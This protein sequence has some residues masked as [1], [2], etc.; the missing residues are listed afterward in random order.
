MQ[1]GPYQGLY[2]RRSQRQLHPQLT[3]HRA[4]LIRCKHLD[5]NFQLRPFARHSKETLFIEE[6]V[7]CGIRAQLSEWGRTKF[8]FKIQADSAP[9]CVFGQVTSPCWNSH[10]SICKMDLSGPRAGHPKISH[11]SILIILNLSYLRSKKGILTLLSLFPLKAGNKSPM[12]VFLLIT[13]I[14][15]TRARKLWAK[16][17]A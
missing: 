1:K 17:P 6:V 3:V 5:D 7:I 8:S 12:W 14:L 2:T 16:K 10:F 4:C 15:I 9:V 13:C 11:N